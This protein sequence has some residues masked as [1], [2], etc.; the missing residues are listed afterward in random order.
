VVLPQRE[1]NSQPV[2]AQPLFSAISESSHCARYIQG[3]SPNLDT[4]ASG[5]A[6][7]AFDRLLQRRHNASQ[8]GLPTGVNCP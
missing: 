7:G 2:I 3:R 4:Y 1:Y 6:P 5:A 8:R